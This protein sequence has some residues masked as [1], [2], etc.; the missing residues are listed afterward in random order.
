[1]SKNCKA[2]FDWT[3]SKVANYRISKTISSLSVLIKK[4]KKKKEKKLTLPCP[5]IN[6]VMFVD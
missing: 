4:K 6:A 1:M 3:D 2:A 5:L